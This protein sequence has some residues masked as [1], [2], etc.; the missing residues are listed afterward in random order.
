M[1]A[2]NV[3]S[4]FLSLVIQKIKQMDPDIFTP[5]N[6]HIGKTIQLNLN[7][8]LNQKYFLRIE[9]NNILLSYTQTPTHSA[10]IADLTLTAKLLD[11]G[12]FGLAYLQS[13]K[14]EF[15]HLL[16]RHHIQ[17]IGDIALLEAFQTLL[18][19][20]DLDWTVLWSSIVG[21]KLAYP[22]TQIF[23]QT[24]NHLAGLAFNAQDSLKNYFLYENK[25]FV[26]KQ[27]LEHWIEKNMALKNNAERLEQNIALLKSRIE[28]LT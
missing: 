5:L 8:N 9:K 7:L 20:M 24:K 14:T 15:T 25:Y 18:Q 19:Q 3:L 1:E 11:L 2:N 12:Q 26:T 23:K 28:K 16:Y 4:T 21:D 6:P 22:M 10:F 17:F 27:E 13:N